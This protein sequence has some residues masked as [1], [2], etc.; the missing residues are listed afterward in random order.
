L[1][2]IHD[3]P[4][5][6]RGSNPY[7]YECE[8]GRFKYEYELG[9][10]LFTPHNGQV[11]PGWERYDLHAP[12]QP[13]T[14]V[15]D[16][17]RRLATVKTSDREIVLRDVPVCESPYNL[18]QQVKVALAQSCQP[19][20]VWRLESIRASVQARQRNKL[21]LQGRLVYPLASHYCQTWQHLPDYDA[22]HAVLIADPAL[23]GKWQRGDEMIYLL[24]F[25][26]DLMHAATPEGKAGGLLTSNLSEAISIPILD[27]WA[28]A[29]WETGMKKELI[30][31]LVCS[32]DCLLGYWLHLSEMN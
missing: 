4:G 29:L 24:V 1:P 20:L 5:L 21:F 17:A 7:D 9:S 28:D 32:G 27:E 6:H 25:E 19:F 23:P 14:A 10:Y 3:V 30:N 13:V 16:R 31:T 8:W 26:S 15:I 22:Y 11:P 12:I 18:L 2:Y